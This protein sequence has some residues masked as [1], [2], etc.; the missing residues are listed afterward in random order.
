M[1][2]QLGINWTSEIYIKLEGSY[3]ELELRKWGTQLGI[4]WSSVITIRESK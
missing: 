1:G 3:L 2:S 4:N